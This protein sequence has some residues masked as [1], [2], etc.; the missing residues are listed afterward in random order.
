[1]LKIC[2]CGWYLGEYDDLYMMLHKLHHKEEIG[3]HVVANKPGSYLEIVDLPYS[4]RENIG[5]EFG[6][7][8]YYLKNI[9]D[10]ESDVLFMHDDIKVHTFMRDF[11]VLPPERLFDHFKT[12][13]V[14]QFYVFNSR[15]E[16]V[17]NDGRHGRMF[18]MSARLLRW[19]KNNGGFGF[20][21]D[22]TGD[23]TT[24]HYNY[25]IEAYDK[26]LDSLYGLFNVKCKTYIRALQLMRRGEEVNDGYKKTHDHY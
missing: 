11:E 17:D 24:G 25:G 15:A 13:T 19:F 2:V 1:M 4:I 20:D 6:A 10:E 26:K 8:D 21:Y 5:L 9:W 3:V 23:T 16:D 22:N 18:M 7:Y 14:D 12:M